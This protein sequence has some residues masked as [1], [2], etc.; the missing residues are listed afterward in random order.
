MQNQIIS[1]IQAALNVAMARPNNAA[2]YKLTEER[3]LSLR[4]IHEGDAAFLL[5]SH[6]FFGGNN[7]RVQAAI[8]RK[9][10]EYV[11]DEVAAKWADKDAK[12]HAQQFAGGR[13]RE[14]FNPLVSSSNVRVIVQS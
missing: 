12:R 13:R 11:P 5:L 6:N 10:R 7:Y 14:P 9:I 8:E 1:A 3:V 2:R 4:K